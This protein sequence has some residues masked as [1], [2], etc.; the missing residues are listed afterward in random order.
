VA[1]CIL[2]ALGFDSS[3]VSFGYLAIWAEIGGEDCVKEIERS[4]QRIL[5]A[6]R[7]ILG[8]IEENK[9]VPNELQITTKAVELV[10][11]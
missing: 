1:Y 4:G 5:E 2:S 9:G 10:A 11:V 7:R 6:S 3:Q 8:W